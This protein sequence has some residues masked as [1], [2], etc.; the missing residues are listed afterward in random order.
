MG[1]TDSSAG[2]EP[3]WSL[4]VRCGFRF[5]FIYFLLFLFCN[6]NVTVFEVIPR[7]GHAIQNALALPF[8]ALGQ[9]IGIEVFHLS[10]V[11]AT[12]HGGGSGDTALCYLLHFSF[13]LI[14]LIGT[15]VWSLLDQHRPH[16]QV[17]YA[18]L[19]FLIRLTLG[20]AMLVYG[21]SKVFPLQMQ[22]P[23]LTILNEN[24]GQSS[25]MTLLWT[26]I[27]LS[28]GYQIVCGAAEV[29]GGVLL[30]FRRTALLGALLTAFVLS[31]VFLYNC[32]FDIP[33]KLFAGHLLLLSLFIVLPDVTALWSF[34][35]LHRPTSPEGVWVPPISRRKFKIATSVIEGVFLVSCIGTMAWNS[36]QSW[37]GYDYNA[38]L[39]KSPLIGIWMLDGEAP[40]SLATGEG[41]PWNELCIDSVRRAFVRSTDGQLWRCS[42]GYNAA[43]QTVVLDYIGS[44]H[45][46]Y[47][48][49]LIDP[50]HLQL[51]SMGLKDQTDITLDLH[52]IAVPTD[53]PLMK[54]G[55]HWLNEWG[56]ER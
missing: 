27:G 6:A 44:G 19:R 35:I 21:F 2:G 11:A 56:Y 38:S 45:R 7:V 5:V 31:N 26:M 34:F 24:Y 36:Y 3:R 37:K 40:A 50:D 25:P 10:G 48:W 12:W 53:Y 14:A 29:A 47:N 46:R 20:L 22:P 42:V 52:R 54:R 18:W 41:K 16:Y 28:P 55:F 32:F 39:V 4:P 30:L 23:S 33:V 17:L 43:K 1:P 51:T 9:I 13:A 15:I 49:Q 8:A